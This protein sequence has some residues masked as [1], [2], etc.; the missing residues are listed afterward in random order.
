MDRYDLL[1]YAESE[2]LDGLLVA[3]DSVQQN[4]IFVSLKN[5]D[6]G[7][8]FITAVKTFLNDSQ[9]CVMNTSTTA[10]GHF[11]LECGTR[12]GDPLSPYLLIIALETFIQVRK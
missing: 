2:N 3:D 11:K 12:Q 5:F 7:E 9:S 8:N 1:S 10:T 4:F 6:F